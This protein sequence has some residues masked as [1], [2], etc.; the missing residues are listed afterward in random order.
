[1]KKSVRMQAV[2]NLAEHQQDKLGRLC[3]ERQ[4]QHAEAEAKLRQLENYQAE[5]RALSAGGSGRFDLNRLEA[6]RLFLVKLGEA[7]AFQRD[8]VAR[9][10]QQVALARAD[11]LASRQRQQQ[12]DTLV[13]GYR[14]DELA[15]DERREQLNAD[16]LAGH[17]HERRLRQ[18]QA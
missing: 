4:R 6:A 5:Y 9:Q 1:M 14:R 16:E 15:R 8:E 13:A 7:I 11:W 3:A 17:R 10:A 12:L 18:P 2:V